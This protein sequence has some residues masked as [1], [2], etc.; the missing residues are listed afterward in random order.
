MADMDGNGLVTASEL[1]AFTAPIVSQFS[2]QT[3]AFGNLVG[4][5]G[6]EFLFEM[7]YESLY[8]ANRELDEEAARLSDELENVRR[9]AREKL[10]RN[11]ALSRRLE[12]EAGSSLSTEEAKIAQANRHHA[13]G[14][15]YVR[16][17]RYEEALVELEQALGLNPGNPTIVNNYGF[18]LYKM[19]RYKESIT[20]FEKTVSLDEDRSVVYVNL[21][22][23]YMNLG[24]DEKAASCYRK[25]LTLW[26]TSPRSKEIRKLLED[27]EK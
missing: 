26:P 18:V 24:E 2:K 12:E 11:L 27:L 16:E 7:S 3:P 1:G 23:A 9:E 4:S 25:Y 10:A 20:W 5:E 15:Q 8:E 17:K 19:G 21:G 14:I 13:L 22:D 6:G